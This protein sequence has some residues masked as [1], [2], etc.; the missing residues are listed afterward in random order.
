MQPEMALFSLP[1][2]SDYSRRGIRIA[3]VG[4]ACT[5]KTHTLELIDPLRTHER[6]LRLY[7]YPSIPHE[8]SSQHL[9]TLKT[10]ILESQADPDLQ[11][12]VDLIWYFVGARWE[13]RD[14]NFVLNFSRLCH[15]IVVIARDDLRDNKDNDGGSE[16]D[17]VEEAVLQDFP[18]ISI[19]RCADPSRGDSHT[20][21]YPKY[22]YD[23]LLNASLELI[24]VLYNRALQRTLNVRKA[25]ERRKAWMVATSVVVIALIIIKAGWNMLGKADKGVEVAVRRTY[26]RFTKAIRS[27]LEYVF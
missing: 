7:E 25:G 26:A 4:P 6:N 27:V 11:N 17:K 12:H 20:S 21:A 5:G 23:V 13:N 16:S 18:G 1:S 10:L 3:L 8:G 19:V 2:Q 9:H 15:V 22:G 14:A 24:P